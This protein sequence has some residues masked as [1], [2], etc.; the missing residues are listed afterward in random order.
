MYRKIG[1]RVLDLLLTITG[2]LLFIPLWVIIAFS[3]KLLS[4]GSVFFVQERAGFQGYPFILYKFRT[5]TDGRD[6]EGNLLPPA[7]RI[8]P[9]GRFLRS[10]SLDELPQLWNVLKGD[11]S[12]IGPRPLLVDYLPLYTEEENRRH[13]VLPGITGWAQVQGRNALS[14]KEKFILDVWYVDHLSFWLDMKIFFLTVWRIV[15]R[16]GVSPDDGDIMPRFTGTQP[17]E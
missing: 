7:E 3:I 5:M 16:E 17:S 8:T 2:L 4:P 11:M 15:K 9:L 14:W 13:E 1:K 6:S 12:L 10:T